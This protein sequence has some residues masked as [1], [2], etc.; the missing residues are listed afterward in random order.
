MSKAGSVGSSGR[1]ESVSVDR[2]VD[3]LARKFALRSFN[4]INIFHALLQ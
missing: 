3:L 2:L 4:S 1:Y